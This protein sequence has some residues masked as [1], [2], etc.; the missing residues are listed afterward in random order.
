MA[1]A[2]LGLAHHLPPSQSVGA[3]S[4]PIV[5]DPVGP[6]DLALEPGRQALA[7]AGLA[8]GDVDLVAFATMTPDVTFPGA[9]CYFQHKIGA[10]TTAA[11]DL[12]GQCA[13]FLTGLMVADAYLTAGIYRHVLLAAGEVHSSG[14]DLDDEQDVEA[15]EQCSVDASEVGRRYSLGL[16]ADEL[17]PRRTSAVTGRVDTCGPEDSPHRRRGKLVSEADQFAVNAAVAQAG[18]SRAS[19]MTKRR[20]SG[21]IGGRPGM[22]VGGWVQCRA[23]IRRCQRST[24]SGR[25]V[26]N[27]VRWRARS[28]AEASTARIARVMPNRTTDSPHATST[29]R[30]DIGITRRSA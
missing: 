7:Q 14:G 3:A 9:A 10:G 5:S 17:G 29:A 15:A 2:I 20:S 19:R 22:A 21:S 23:T 30:A 25:T 24:V 12:R 27:A 26:R 13:G 6:S 1:T 8:I 4:R 28:I 11:V 18:F 16:G